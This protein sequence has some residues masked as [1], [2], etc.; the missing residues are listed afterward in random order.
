MSITTDVFAPFEGHEQVI[1]G[2]DE[3]TGMR[4]V[5]AVHST[6]LGP[7]LG[8]TRMSAY[9]DHPEPTMA[10]YLDALRLSRAMSLKNSLAG[11][12][13]GG[14]KAVLIAD[15]QTKNDELLRA[16]G[17]FL[18]TLGGRYVTASDLGMTVSD[19]DVIA[20]TC[21]WTTGRSPEHGGVG[22]SGILTAVGVLRGMQAAAAHVWGDPTLAGRRVGIVGAGK[23]GGRLATHL[24]DDGADVIV[25]DPSEHARDQV[26]QNTPAVRLVNS[27]DELLASDLDVLSPNAVGGLLTEDLAGQLGV[28]IVCGGANNQLA[29]PQVADQLAA[30]GIVYT[31]DFM[32]N[33]GGVIQV[34]EELQGADLDRARTA[35]ERVFQTTETVLRRAMEEGITPQIA[36]ERQ[37][38]DRISAGG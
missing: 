8:G 26:S 3:A 1:F 5:V 20:E 21:P 2:F 6:E 14:G 16:Y 34:A 15:P 12:P 9:A 22:D 31:P 18:A 36:A 4:A 24:A 23:V 19:M 35:V 13:H 30:R 38:L 32:V 17:R 29:E 10:A 11:L 37:A 27:L 7:A 25:F 33:C 28:A